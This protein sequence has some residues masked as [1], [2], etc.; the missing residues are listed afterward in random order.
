MEQDIRFCTAPDGVRIAYA[1]TGQGPPLVKAAHWLSHLEYDG[2][3]PVWGHWIR[4][5]SR[6][7]TLVRYDERGCGLS[8]WD[9]DD[10]SFEAWVRD[11]ETVVDT[12][13][14]DRFPL[15]GLSQGGAVAVAYAMRHPEKVSHLILLGSYARGWLKR[16]T[17]PRHFEQAEA[18]RKL[19]RSGWG[20]D[21]PAF[22]QIFTALMIPESTR[23]QE[24]S[25]N[26][27]QRLSTSPEN[28]VKF[29]STFYTIDVSDLARQIAVPTL[30]LHARHDAAIS[31]NAG[32]E[33]AALIPDARFVPLEAKNHVLLEDEPAWPRFLSEV[34]RFLGLPNTEPS[35]PRTEAGDPLSSLFKHAVALSSSGRAAFLDAACAGNPT[36]RYELESLLRAHDK[37]EDEAFL[38]VPIAR[39]AL[40][41]GTD[42]FVDSPSAMATDRR[43]G[44]YQLLDL[45]GQGGMGVVYKA[46]DTRLDRYVA[47][48]FLSPHLSTHPEAKARFVQEARAASALD[49]AN[50]CTIYDI[51]ESDDGRL[52]MAMTFC[53]GQTLKQKMAR[54]RLSLEDSLHIA[55]QVADGLQ[56][57]HEAGII[58]R[59]LKP[60]NLMLT[61]QGR[62]RILDFGIAKL[63]GATEWTRPGT[64]M[65]TV[66]YMSPE[67]AHGDRIDHRTDLWSLGVVLYEMLT[68]T[69]P[70]RGEYEQAMLY[71]ILHETPTPVRT[72]CPEAPDALV[73]IVENL[74]RKDPGER[75][76]DMATVS[77]RLLDV[78]TPSR[79][80]PERPAEVA[81]ITPP[82][83]GET[84]AAMDSETWPL[85]PAGPGPMVGRTDEC[86]WLHYHLDEALAGK[87]RVVFV[88]GGAGVGKT[89]LVEAFVRDAKR[90]A[91]VWI[92]HGQCLEHRGAGEAYMPVLDALSRLCR[93]QGGQELI[94]LLATHAPT[95]LVQMPWLVDEAK[96][97][98][99]QHRAL[100]ATK[101]RMLREMV[102]TLDALTAKRPLILVL[103]DLHW[104]DRSTVDLITWLARRHEPARLL[105]IGTYRPADVKR[106]HPPLHA[107]AQELTARGFAETRA[108]PFLTQTAIG[109]YLAERFP[110]IA[111]PDR[112]AR[113]VHQRT[114]GNALFMGNVIEAWVT[115]GRLT[116][117][118]GI[119]T[120][121]AA[122]DDLAVGVP[123]SL[124]Q[125]IEQQLGELSPEDLGILEAASVAG[126]AFSAAGVAAGVDAPEEAVEARCDALARQ[127]HFLW[128][129]G[130]AEWADGTIAGRYGFIH[131]LYQEVLYERIPAGRRVRLHRQI[132]SR[133]E[134]G[135]SPHAGKQAAELAVHFVRGRDAERAVRY[136]HFAAQQAMYRSALREATE[137]LTQG[138]GILKKETDFPERDRQELALQTALGGAM[139]LTRGWAAPEAEAAYTRARDLCR[140]LGDPPELIPLLHRMATLYELR[141]E[142][143]VAESLIAQRLRLRD[144]QD[145][146]FILESYELLSC[147][148]FH[149]AD[150]TRSL[151]HARQGLTLY[152]PGEHSTFTAVFGDNP[153]ISCQT[154]AALALWF[155]GYPDQALEQL[156]KALHLAEMP[157]NHYNLAHCQEQ[158]AV[159]YQCR[160]EIA[161]TREWAAATT[162]VATRQGF[163]YRIAT[164][165]ILQGWAMAF[166]GEGHAGINHIRQGLLGCDRIGARMDRPYYLGLLAEACAATDR[167]DEG[168]DALDEALAT[169]RNSRSF[170]YEAELHRIKGELLFQ[171]GAR[172]DR[173][174]ACFQQ[175]LALARDQQA[176]S[177]ELR[178]AMSQARLW[179][180]GDKHT[181]AHHRLAEVYGTFTEGFG[182]PD[183]RKAKALLETMETAP[184]AGRLTGG[185]AWPWDRDPRTTTNSPGIA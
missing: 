119:W 80:L 99:L 52:F 38:D 107:A 46:R 151:E 30:I 108:L 39:I 177:V 96:H 48:K 10:F 145:A 182:T 73:R 116:Q 37:A 16:T 55:R 5:L 23:E 175:A 14:L 63:E 6:Q 43:V 13:G 109:E 110:G 105:L 3:S 171:A 58:H 35:G 137:L 112:L 161:A 22:R 122:L 56:C 181:E 101:E 45:V 141:G 153:G 83:H 169:V 77:S 2:S 34:R 27:L 166:Q 11:L 41:S 8:D 179:R 152:D 20:Q 103:E 76:P 111:L 71:S 17:K 106:R 33:L 127:G 172:N 66:A 148:L 123:G 124:R 157:D 140:T 26:D 81:R 174:E 65:G 131:A 93:K 95:W 62:V 158:A 84:P 53:T 126:M 40:P 156:N 163:A 54:G 142:Y 155:L 82:E 18:L 162:A 86:A 100:G 94:T 117:T 28:A 61:E 176:R 68:G 178:T 104:S 114:D 1:T 69:R 98:A 67:Q 144:P 49:H 160:R 21:N 64:Q 24:R 120:L 57:A 47:L 78:M 139:A 134:A 79:H 130:V 44:A 128:S 92:G 87:R 146:A 170:F 32:R 168:L 4:A 36:L 74:L 167:L 59:D 75:Y 118:D 154:W 89:T 147:S 7:H 143:E 102:E 165:M 70:F 121:R 185:H 164:G 51:G 91:A 50:I 150:F 133:L 60:A 88:T 183:L 90:R 85:E 115:Q 159:F 125:L 9:V 184:S 42:A 15:L 149:Q 25:F 173:V 129:R 135:Y 31:F 12:L 113:L 19:T 72:L 132:G 138:L 180:Q 136:L 29:L 97:A